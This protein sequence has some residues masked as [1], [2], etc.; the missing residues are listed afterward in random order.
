MR[1]VLLAM[2]FIAI[3]TVV[4]I[5][6][7]LQR[8]SGSVKPAETQVDTATA[9]ASSGSNIAGQ[10]ETSDPPGA[11][12]TQQAEPRPVGTQSRTDS[13]NTVG[14]RQYDTGIRNDQR[15]RNTPAGRPILT[16]G[17]EIASRLHGEDHSA[18]EDLQT[19]DELLGLFRLSFN[20]NPLAGDNQ[21][22]MEALMGGNPGNLVVFPRD[23]PSLDAEGQLL[24]RWGTPYFFHAL[25]GQE[26]E[27]FS[28]GPD[29]EFNTSDD[30]QF[31]D[32]GGQPLTG[33]DNPEPEI[34]P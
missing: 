11:P 1:K 10:Q 12:A 13:S 31:S 7:R 2:V 14:S 17:I 25:S 29:R 19:L 5:V 8:D 21:M 34:D 32:R 18:E 3:V 6:P 28:A 30:I 16:E 22:V 26:M 9:S 20:E 4:A 33:E 15:V 23:H 27:I 24:D